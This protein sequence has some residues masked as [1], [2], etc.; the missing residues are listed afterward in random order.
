MVTRTS[1]NVTSY[2][3]YIAC[4]VMA[5]LRAEGNVMIG[6]MVTSPDYS[7]KPWQ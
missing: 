1:H 5:T 4:L 2:V 7:H 3:L 6:V